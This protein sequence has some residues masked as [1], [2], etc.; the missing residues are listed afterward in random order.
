MMTRKDWDKDAPAIEEWNELRQRRA[1]KLAIE[2][3]KEESLGISQ[4][5]ADINAHALL[6]AQRE[7]MFKM[8]RFFETLHQPLKVREAAPPQFAR[9]EQTQP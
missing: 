6:N 5:V 4:S 3:A 2:L 9:G 8:I 1:F 7:G